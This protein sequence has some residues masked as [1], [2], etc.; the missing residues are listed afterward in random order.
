MEFT[1]HNSYVIL[2]PISS[3]ALLLTQKLLKIGYVAPMLMSSIQILF[4][5]YHKMD[6]HYEISMDLL[7]FM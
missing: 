1:F 2:E 7:L 4:S 6:D 3:T 5:R